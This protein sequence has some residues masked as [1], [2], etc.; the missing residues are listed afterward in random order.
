MAHKYQVC[1]SFLS[2]YISSCVLFRGHNNSLPNPSF[3]HER[4]IN[5]WEYPSK[6]SLF[7]KITNGEN[8]ERREEASNQYF[9]VLHVML[10]RLNLSLRKRIAFIQRRSLVR[11]HNGKFRCHQCEPNHD[12]KQGFFVRDHFVN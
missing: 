3:Q 8:K 11:S 2:Q 9:I 10:R 7:C 5:L 12:I 4:D 1:S 6:Y